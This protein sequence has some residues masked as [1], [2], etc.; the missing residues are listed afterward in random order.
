MT[1]ADV[2][3]LIS[4]GRIEVVPADLA[5]AADRLTVVRT[6][7]VA[8]S[9]IA[10]IDPD[11]AYALAYDA[12]RKAVTAHMLASGARPRNRSGSH[13]AVAQYAVAALGEANRAG[14]SRH[15]D[16]MRRTR[17][18]GEY[19]GGTVT[20]RQATHAIQVATDLLALVEARW[21]TG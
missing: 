7:L 17:N 16:R 3:A 21:P 8:A 2:E 20:H 5:A 4:A 9:A 15:L 14:T 19:S 10:E 6:H 11:G 1:S 18:S 13:Q 12:A